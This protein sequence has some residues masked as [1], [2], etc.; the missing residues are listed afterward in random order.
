MR[1]PRP[2]SAI[3]LLVAALTLAGQADLKSPGY[4]AYQKANELFSAHKLRESETSLDEALRLDPNLLPALTL[5]ARLA[6]AENRYALARQTL[7]RAI[8]VAPSSWYAHFLYGLQFYLGNEMRL[9]QKPLETAR[10][11]N[12]QDPRAALYLGLTYESVGR[13]EEG[14]ALYAEARRLEEALGESHPDTLL[15]GARLLLLLDRLDQ[16]DEWIRTALKLEPNSRDAHFE[17]GRLL[18]KKGDARG[19]I[20]EGEA[21]LRL[22]GVEVTDR[23]VHYLL[24]RAYRADGQDDLASQ[25]AEALRAAELSEFK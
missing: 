2:A 12:P 14:L 19:A 20:A 4:S 3:L 24:V 17:L 21:A 6:M 1:A 10:K 25:H 9:A 11:L 23:Q 16:S 15:I 13:T 18:L 7:E 5:R 22:A 8:K